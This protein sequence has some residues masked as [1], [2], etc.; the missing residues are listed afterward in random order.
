MGRKYKSSDVKPLLV[1]ARLISPLC[2]DAPNLDSLLEEAMLVKMPSIIASRN[3]YRHETA[4][5]PQRGDVIQAGRI[6]IPLGR[7]QLGKWNVPQCSSPILSEVQAETVGYV[8]RKFP[9]EYGFM[10]ATK[11]QTKVSVADGEFRSYHLPRRERLVTHVRW[12]AVGNANRMR[13]LL[14]A[15]VAIGKETNIGYGRVGEWTVERID[16]DFSW[17][18]DSPDGKVLMRPLP[19]IKGLPEITG[20]RKALASCVSP[21]WLPSNFTEVWLPC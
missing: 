7:R 17:F 21:Y 6:P 15:V 13:Q 2:Q 19:V 3:G 1:T 20:A 4:L 12:F 9:T 14:K 10:L 18:A 11:Q 5:N 8:N 16:D